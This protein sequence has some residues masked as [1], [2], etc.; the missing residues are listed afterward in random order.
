[1]AAAGGGPNDLFSFDSSRTPWEEGGSP[2]FMNYGGPTSA[3]LRFAALKVCAGFRHKILVPIFP[4]GAPGNAYYYVAFFLT[5][6]EEENRHMFSRSPFFRVNAVQVRIEFVDGRCVLRERAVKVPSDLVAE[7]GHIAFTSERL[8]D[9]LFA[10]LFWK[11]LFDE[12]MIR[13]DGLV[14]RDPPFVIDADSAVRYFDGPNR[15]TG[16]RTPNPIA[17]PAGF[18]E[19]DSGTLMTVLPA[20]TETP[21]TAFH[22]LVPC[23]SREFPSFIAVCRVA[24]RMGIK[25]TYFETT[26]NGERIAQYPVRI[27]ESWPYHV[28]PPTRFTVF[29]D[30]LTAEERNILIQDLLREIWSRQDHSPLVYNWRVGQSV[31]LPSNTGFLVNLPAVNGVSVPTR[32]RSTLPVE[33]ALRVLAAISLVSSTGGV[34]LRLVPVGNAESEYVVVHRVSKT[35]N[36]LYASVNGAGRVAQY[37]MTIPAAVYALPCLSHLRIEST[38]ITDVDPLFVEVIV[39]HWKEAFYRCAL[40]SH[41]D[42]LPSVCGTLVVGSLGGGFI[43]APPITY[44]PSGKFMVEFMLRVALPSKERFLFVVPLPDRENVVAVCVKY[45][46]VFCKNIRVRP[47]P[48]T[49]C[50]V[51]MGLMPLMRGLM[52]LAHT[53]NINCDDTAEIFHKVVRAYWSKLDDE[54]QFNWWIFRRVAFAMGL[55][56]R[57]GGESSVRALGNPLAARIADLSLD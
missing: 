36:I 2:D 3:S 49:Y 31:V 46:N 10:S 50:D 20:A 29:S 22:M 40:G 32:P 30:R 45:G 6:I 28:S 15:F 14:V 56:P 39:A 26:G 19:I 52:R 41:T 12:C 33:T 25:V 4:D 38:A 1:M 51:D 18:V 16:Y 24:G 53:G 21:E 34:T 23:L 42:V 11:P 7:F 8:T 47:G 13:V 17:A 35:V 27:G 5:L 57:L 54:N 44:P 37:V 48:F 9:E 55:H 43:A